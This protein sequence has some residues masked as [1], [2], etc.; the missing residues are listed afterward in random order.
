MRVG[1]EDEL[2]VGE[3]IGD[4][5]GALGQDVEVDLDRLGLVHILQVGAVPAEGF[6]AL[7]D[8]QARRVD[9]AALED[10]EEILGAILPYHADQSDGREKT[11]GVGEVDGGAAD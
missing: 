6:T 11:R 10:V 8:F 7:P 4:S 5:G 3:L 9:V 2:A 1:E